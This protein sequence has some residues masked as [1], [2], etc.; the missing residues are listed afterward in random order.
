MGNPEFIL[1]IIIIYR[2]M[3]LYPEE[4]SY[5]QTIPSIPLSPCI[6]FRLWTDEENVVFMMQYAYYLP[7]Y[8]NAWY[9]FWVDCYACNY[10]GNM[11]A[12]LANIDKI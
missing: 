5:I 11:C 3:L 2:F 1:I 8:K 9:I 10:K 12:S 6:I 7:I 4:P